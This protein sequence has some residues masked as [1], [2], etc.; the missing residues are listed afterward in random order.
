ME[1]DAVDV[2]KSLREQLSE[3]H[4]QIALLSAQLSKSSSGCDHSQVDS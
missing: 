2:V 4:Y 1:V 3:A